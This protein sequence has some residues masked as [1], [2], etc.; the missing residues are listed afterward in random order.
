MKPIL[1]KEISRKTIVSAKGKSRIV[2]TNLYKCECGNEY[3]ANKNTIKNGYKQSCGCKLKRR[4]VHHGYST[5]RI[6]KNWR[7]IIS[8]CTNKNISQY[9]NYG[10][11]G[12]TVCEE[13]KNSF[14][15]FYK[16][17]GQKPGPEYSI[18]R[19]DNNKGYCKENC[20]WSTQKEQLANRRNTILLTYKGKTKTIKEWAGEL[21]ISPELI[22]N[23]YYRKL[24]V[25]RILS[26]ERL[27]KNRK[28]KE[29]INCTI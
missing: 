16:D 7:D 28:C 18:D 27:Y 23:R 5:T 2:K 25:E 22:T 19:I 29:E 11:R 14:E 10:G 12:I 17:M 4:I 13:W 8:R 26:T 6:Y 20:K 1:V 3:V 21:Q 9:K 24:P 15:Q